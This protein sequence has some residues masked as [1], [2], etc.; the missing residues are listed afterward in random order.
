MTESRPSEPE[1]APKQP[2]PL[3]Q[4]DSSDLFENGR[5]IVIV[6]SGEQYRLLI[7]RNDKLILQK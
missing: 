7:T 6:H 3:K 4:I 5:S 2:L 1:A